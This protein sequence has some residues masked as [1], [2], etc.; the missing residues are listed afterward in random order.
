MRDRIP[1]GRLL[2][3]VHELARRR[4]SGGAVVV[5]ALALAPAIGLGI[6]SRWASAEADDREPAP[7]PTSVAVTAPATPTPVLSL[8]RIPEAVADP[9]ALAP[10]QTELD[11]ISGQLPDSA[12]LVVR[13]DG[14]P[15][16]DRRGDRA[17]VPAS[18]MKLLTAFTALAVLG[19]DTTYHTS[20]LASGPVG[21]GVLGGDLYLRGG[22]DPMLAT[23]GYADYLLEIGKNGI[24]PHTSLEQLADQVV[25]AGVTHISGRVVG[26]ESRYDTQRYLPTWPEGYRTFPEIG[27]QS[28]LSV[29]DGYS[30]FDPLTPSPAPATASA[31]ILAL[32]LEERGVTIDGEPGEGATPPEATELTG[33]DSAPMRDIMGEM[34][35]ESD[36]GT[37]ELVLKEIGLKAG[38]QGTTAAGVQ[39][40]AATLAARGVPATGVSV[41]DGSG[42]SRDNQVT[43]GAF[44][45]IL[46][47][48][49]LGGPLYDAMAVA[50]ETGT[51]A[52]EGRFADS[53]AKGILHGKSGRLNGIS[54]FSGVV[55][56]GPAGDEHRFTFSILYNGD[57]A[58]ARAEALWD[59]LAAAL[60][61]YPQRAPIEAFAPPPV[62]AATMAPSPSSG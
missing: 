60:V 50:G 34:L 45:A 46:D 4:R 37:A 24:E 41:Q 14:Q 44:A 49:E 6:T 2:P 53:P 1:P 59:P 35:R 51:L 28:A 56:A 5:A 33:I 31:L 39:A 27:P 48:P 15:L 3:P 13:L 12:C 62:L 30:P 61:A 19:P 38:G 58:V 40:V 22:G 57:G 10:L 55:P 9:I 23:Q 43:C 21:D 7:V 36:N 20:V 18:N 47:D 16:Y 11:R 17:L 42:L 25:A 26:D 54:S 29:N 32:E 52:E 8:R